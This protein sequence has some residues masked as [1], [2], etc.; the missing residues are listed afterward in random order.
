M[1]NR[2]G[3]WKTHSGNSRRKLKGEG[4]RAKEDGGN[5]KRRLLTHLSH[6]LYTYRRRHIRHI[7]GFLLHGPAEKSHVLLHFHSD[8]VVGKIRANSQFSCVTWS[9]TPLPSTSLATSTPSHTHTHTLLDTCA[10]TFCPWERIG[11]L[12]E[13]CIIRTGLT[14]SPVHSW[15]GHTQTQSFSPT[16]TLSLS[17]SMAS[18]LHGA[19]THTCTYRHKKHVSC[20]RPRV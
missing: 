5:Q 9:H 4:E 8:W 16:A 17:L 1:K 2:A 10:H 11:L 7:K 3:L 13:R 6:L 15:A 20:A 18:F 14:W 12:L 19:H